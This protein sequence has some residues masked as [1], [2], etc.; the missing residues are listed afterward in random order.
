[1]ILADVTVDVRFGAIAST[2][3][4]AMLKTSG[5]VREDAFNNQYRETDG[6]VTGKAFEYCCYPSVSKTVKID[7]DRNVKAGEQ[8]AIPRCRQIMII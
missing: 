1:M 5:R 2:F 3:V 8:F 4:N 7:S 6:F